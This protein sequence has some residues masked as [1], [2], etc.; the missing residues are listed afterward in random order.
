MLGLPL[1]VA[2][3]WY[4]ASSWRQ[5]SFRL[6]SSAFPKWST[7]SCA[8]WADVSPRG[9]SFLNESTKS[10]TSFQGNT[11]HNH[12]YIAPTTL[13][14]MEHTK[15]TFLRTIDP[16]PSS[17]L[18]WVISES[19]CQTGNMAAWQ[20]APHWKPAHEPFP[21]PSV[22]RAGSWSVDHEFDLKCPGNI[23]KFW[24]GK[25]KCIDFFVGVQHIFQ[26]TGPRP[27]HRL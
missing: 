4:H 3:S 17:D 6:S 12:Y 13:N 14:K 25:L 23:W 11:Q 24:V 10:R 26:C 18:H 2:Y 1:L 15:F 22:W 9:S 21:Q 27:V 7:T 8:G 16:S 19:S 20:V 5:C